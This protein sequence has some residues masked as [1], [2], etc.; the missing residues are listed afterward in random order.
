MV[1]ARA[2]LDRGDGSALD[3]PIPRQSVLAL[4][5]ELLLRRRISSESALSQPLFENAWRLADYL[6]LLSG[7][8]HGLADRRLA[9]FERVAT[10]LA[11]VNLLQQRYDAAFFSPTAPA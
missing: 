11:G 2:L 6:K 7:E 10:A 3:P 1:V 4:G 9:F 5:E 8:R